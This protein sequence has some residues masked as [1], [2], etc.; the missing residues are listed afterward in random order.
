MSNSY[1]NSTFT[2]AIGTLARSSTLRSQFALVEAGFTAIESALAPKASPTFTGNATM[3]NVIY[4]G[5][6][7]GGTGVLNIGSG[8]VYKD[9]SGNVGIG[10]ASPGAKFHV[11][12]SVRLDVAVTATN[13]GAGGADPLP[14]APAGY[15]LINVGGVDR[16]LPY[17]P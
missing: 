4:T 9:G 16:K 17:Y 14:A 12:G 7:T 15:M 11:N 5:T 2:A 6:F 1:Y 3:A 8:Q 13:S 10:T